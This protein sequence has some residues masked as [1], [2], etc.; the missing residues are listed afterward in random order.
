[1]KSMVLEQS[2]SG[3]TLMMTTVSRVAISLC[4]CYARL[5]TDTC[6]AGRMEWAAL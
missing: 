2:S 3:M 1:M 6:P 5:Q 4:I